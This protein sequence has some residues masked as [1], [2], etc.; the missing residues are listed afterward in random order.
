VKVAIHQP[1]FIPWLGY[2]H[3]IREV[4]LF[5][6]YDDVQFEKKDYGNRNLIKTVTGSQWLT[7]PIE[8][9]GK[10]FQSFRDCRIQQKYFVVKKMIRTIEINY[11]KAPFFN[12]FFPQFVDILNKSDNMLTSLNIAIIIWACKIFNIQTKFCCS[13]DLPKT[14]S[15]GP[16]R[17]VELCKAVK[18]TDYLSG[19]GAK[20]F[21]DENGFLES[22]INLKYSTFISPMYHQQFG[23]F[24]PNLSVIDYIFNAGNLIF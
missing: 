12:E 19:T 14:V 13:S 3:K 16:R 9:S 5:I 21:N 2:F 4:D 8:T 22:G 24:I 17:V 10:L 1:N 15:N 6:F 20:A 18:A 7:L 23:T 11:S